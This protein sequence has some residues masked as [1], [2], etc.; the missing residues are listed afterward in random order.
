MAAKKKKNLKTKAVAKKTAVKKKSKK[1][2]A[3]KKT[4]VKAKKTKAKVA[5][6]K[7]K[8][9]SAKKAVQAARKKTPTKKPSQKSAGRAVVKTAAVVPA[10]KTVV[11]YAKA[12]TPLGDRLVVR[13]QSGERMTAGGLIIPDTAMMATGYLKAIVLATGTGSK[14]KKGQ[15]RPLDVQIGDEVL[16]SEH[17]GVKI[18]FNSEDLQIVHETDVMGIVQK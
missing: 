15:L 4:A 18:R 11:D 16:F 14:N 2:P 10:K 13:V 1:A 6:A 17:A 9:A 3:I 12:V 5:P 8:K 7:T